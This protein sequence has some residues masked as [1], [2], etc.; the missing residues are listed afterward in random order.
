MQ[1][2]I[3]RFLLSAQWWC[4]RL[5]N[6]EEKKT[7]LWMLLAFDIFS[8]LAAALSVA[9]AENTVIEA[10]EEEHPRRRENNF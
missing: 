8:T 2:K 4:C 5:V 3:T 10:N 1:F 7:S 6:E 9:H